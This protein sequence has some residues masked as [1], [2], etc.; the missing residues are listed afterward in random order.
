MRRLFGG[1]G[2][3]GGASG[4]KPKKPIRANLGDE[5]SFYYDEKLKSWVDRKDKR[6]GAGGSDGADASGALPPPPTSAPPTPAMTIPPS[7]PS[8]A[9]PGPSGDGSSND[10]SNPSNPL[11]RSNSLSHVRNRYVD[12]FAGGPNSGTSTPGMGSIPAVGSTPNLLAPVLPGSFVPAPATG[13]GGPG[14]PM[15]PGGGTGGPKFFVP[16]VPSQSSMTETSADDDD[17][18]DDVLAGATTGGGGVHTG[19]TG[20]GGG[21]DRLII[22][23]GGATGEDGS[24]MLRG[25]GA[26]T[27]P[28][29]KTHH[30]SRGPKLVG[31]ATA[32]EPPFAEG[33]E[34]AGVGAGS[35]SIEPTSPPRLVN[36]NPVN[37]TSDPKARLG[38]WAQALG[39]VSEGMSSPKAVAS[40]RVSENFTPAEDPGPAYPPTSSRNVEQEPG[41]NS[42]VYSST[43]NASSVPNPGGGFF[44]PAPAHL[45]STQGSL[46]ARSSGNSADSA[47]LL[48]G[49]DASG[50]PA[51]LR[52]GL[53]QG[54]NKRRSGGAR[55]HTE[56]L[57]D[58]P[59]D[60]TYSERQAKERLERLSGNAGYS[61]PDGTS[62]S[63][64]K[65]A[66]GGAYQDEYSEYRSEY[67]GDY[68]GD[69]AYASEYQGASDPPV[70]ETL[71]T[72]SAEQSLDYQV[73]D[74]DV[75]W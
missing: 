20:G 26:T 25:E 75:T 32:D 39:K 34:T 27:S 64:V 73:Q 6:A 74:G 65:A 62:T 47:G 14:V 50:E 19:A 70:D 40:A 37:V 5:S 11:S 30:H 67:Q 29:G 71:V 54:G 15:T 33:T 9:H 4:E 28:K 21:L 2:A 44:V 53:P 1:L 17:G 18:D 55:Q 59:A 51:L 31:I 8:N 69:Y 60:L 43:S 3:R 13:G 56:D 36:L 61:V 24:A 57:P 48:G 52:P 7:G 58:V 66:Y 35:G 63:P 72:Q 38:D 22:P 12:V 45:E 16:A 42:S 46:D 41:A 10:A 23:G 49:D 68:Q